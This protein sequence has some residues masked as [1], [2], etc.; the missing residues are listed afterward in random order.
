[1]SRVTCSYNLDQDRTRR[2]W[3]G[4]LYQTSIQLRRDRT[5]ED[6]V[7]M[8]LLFSGVQSGPGRAVVRGDHYTKHIA[9]GRDE[10]G[11][12]VHVFTV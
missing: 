7:Y 8:Y 6:D 4:P 11:R 9:P 5:S 1:M 2:G 10:R 3:R 12:C